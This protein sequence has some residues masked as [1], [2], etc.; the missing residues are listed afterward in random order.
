[1]TKVFKILHCFVILFFINTSYLYA[2][3]LLD[4]ASSEV[5][6][7]D[8][9]DTFT[10]TINIISRSG[11][12]FILSN[13][14]QLLGKG[15]FVT[16]SIKEKGP[17]ARAVVAKSHDGQAGIKV[18]KVYSLSRWKMI[19]KGLSVDVLKGDDS[20]LFTPKKT[21]EERIVDDSKIESEEDLFNEKA[22]INE[23][24][25]DFY[26]DSRIIKPDNIV[27]IAYN[28]FIFIDEKTGDPFGGN[29]FNAAWAYQ[30]SDNYWVE[31]LVGSTTVNSYPVT[32]SQT[33]ITNFTARFKYSIKAPLYS[34]F[35]P[36]I[37]FQSISVSSP[38]AGKTDQSTTQDEADKELETIEEI[39]RT[40]IIAGVTVLR[41]LVPGWFLKADLGTDFGST[42]INVG[43]GIEF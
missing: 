21:E 9:A 18:L 8:N 22:L 3:D 34:Y 43:F 7:G 27:T 24:L 11:K 28:Q 37:G 39:E 42:I 2:Q 6:I 26:K 14:N 16:I 32:S 5:T 4:D 41:R 1:M 36:Y 23:D 31:A 17:V 35:F 12:V 25:A 30:F 19:T 20:S 13:S 40:D 10:E 33:L 29:Q 38:D 15:D